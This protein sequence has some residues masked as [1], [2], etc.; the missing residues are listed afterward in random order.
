[1]LGTSPLR[2][3]NHRS[4]SLSAGQHPMLSE[5]QSFQYPAGEHRAVWEPPVLEALTQM[6]RLNSTGGHGSHYGL[7]VSGAMKGNMS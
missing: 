3:I 1:M 2:S 5:W 4:Y 7:Q 6:Q